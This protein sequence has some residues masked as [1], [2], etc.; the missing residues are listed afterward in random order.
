MSMN[1]SFLLPFIPWTDQSKL[2]KTTRSGEERTNREAMMLGCRDQI[3]PGRK[4]IIVVNSVVS[5][6]KPVP[7]VLFF[8][9]LLSVIM[10]YFS[11]L[12]R[13]RNIFKVSTNL[14]STNVAAEA[15]Y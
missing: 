8:S 4:R 12:L 1:L 2:V 11:I 3:R 10:N 15:H 14:L 7:L 13:V 5:Y 9:H 6:S